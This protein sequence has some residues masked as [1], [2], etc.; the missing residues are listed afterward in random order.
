[1]RL[2]TQRQL[3]ASGPWSFEPPE[4]EQQIE[5]SSESRSSDLTYKGAPPTSLTLK[6]VK[7][8]YNKGV[9]YLKGKGVEKSLEEAARYF[10][11]AAE[12]GYVDAQYAIGVQYLK[13]QGVKKDVKEAAMWLMTA[14]EE[15]HVK[16][17]YNVGLMHRHGVGVPMDQELATTWTHRAADRGH[18]KARTSDLLKVFGYGPW[19]GYDPAEMG[20]ET[21]RGYAKR[22]DK[23]A[24][25]RMGLLHLDGEMVEKDEALAF[26]WFLQAA[27]QGVPYA[28][29]Q[30]SQMYLDGIGVALDEDA[31]ERYIK[32]AAEGGYA[33]AE[34]AYG[35]CLYY[36]VDN[37]S[38]AERA[39]AAK[40]FLRAAIQ[41]LPDGQEEIG[42]LTFIGDGVAPD[43]KAG[44]AWMQKA[45][46]GGS[47]AARYRLS[48]LSGSF[49]ANPHQAIFLGG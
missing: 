46:E 16:A 42:W 40:F 38:P 36:G 10:R 44:I 35:R 45:A 29:W 14:A 22:G 41:G 24:Q 20:V 4:N 8:I 26:Q 5:G 19:M 30:V 6:E 43:R 3:L 34:C 9:Q 28:Q 2:V 47:Q 21:I 48:T 33:E 12:L 11:Q 15:G 7:E 37:P 32:L 27:K 49:L 23:N 1:M 18:K 39:E 17:M 13:G 31:A 25:I